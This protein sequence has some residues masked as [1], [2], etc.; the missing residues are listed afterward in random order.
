MKIK[1]GDQI[2]II[3]GKER[4]RT[5]K[6]LE[7]LPGKQRIVVEGINIR[8]KHVRP[9]RSGE[10]GQIVQLPAPIHISNVK[11]ICKNCKNPTR[12][13][14]KIVEGKKYRICKK[15]GQET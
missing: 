5:G 14:Y 4:G 10:K 15:C 9:K 11:L 1:K 7:A 12:V 3:S 13:G 6:V 2:L 8:K